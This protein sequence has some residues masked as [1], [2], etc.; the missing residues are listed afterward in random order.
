MAL[1]IL[2]GWIVG[3]TVAL[4]WALAATVWTPTSGRTRMFLLNPG[5]R[6]MAILFLIALA[7]VAA[8]FILDWAQLCSGGFKGSVRCVPAFPT[9]M[10]DLVITLAIGFMIAFYY[11]GIVPTAMLVILAVALEVLTR[12]RHP[13]QHAGR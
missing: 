1:A 8:A 13:V 11:F 9:V 7:I 6:Y 4:F 10:G 5:V 2:V 3:V 12:A